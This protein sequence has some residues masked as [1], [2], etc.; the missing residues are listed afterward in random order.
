MRRGRVIRATGAM[1]IGV[2]LILAGYIPR[3]QA[4]RPHASVTVSVWTAYNGAQL[5]AFLHLVDEFQSKYPSITV[6]EESSA[7]YG[8]LQQK[9]QSAVF[10]NNVPTLAQGYEN[11]VAGFVKSNAVQEL[12]PYVNGKQGL[13]KKDIADFF[14]KDWADGLLGKQRVMMP[15]SK[16]D[17]V[18]YFDGPMLR[19]Y[20]I[21][22]PPTNYTQFAA[23]C[24][25]VTTSGSHPAQWCMT[26]EE[27]TS[28]FYTWE[29]EWG[30]KVV[31]GNKAVFATKPGAAALGFWQSL[32]RKHEVVVSTCATCYQGQA[33]F[34]AGKTPFYI[35]SS[36]GLPFVESGA[37]PGVAVGEH[38]L[39]AGPVR[40]ATEVYGAPLF[41]FKNAPADQKAA[42]WLFLKFITEP[43]QTAYWAINTGY[44]PVRRS[45]LKP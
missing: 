2:G 1:A 30:A 18:F 25:K 36:A 45:A 26:L 20:G 40:Q 16:S 38:P 23:D 44:M 3:A 27:Y 35:G 5:K 19:R 21:K 37:K 6:K 29:N 12:T 17:Q 4:A 7:N 10:A 8:A 39:P 24:K 22:S 31:S 14:S 33:D 42:G 41:M 13:S 32:V 34:D 11:V 28:N 43:A 9:E 15:F